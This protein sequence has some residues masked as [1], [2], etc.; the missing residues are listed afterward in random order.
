MPKLRG[1][2]GLARHI[3]KN[4]KNTAKSG[5][6]AQHFKPLLSYQLLRVL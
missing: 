1:R 6:K 5:A 4:V 2:G 3:G